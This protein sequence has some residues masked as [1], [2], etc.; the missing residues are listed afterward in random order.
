[1]VKGFLKK[2]KIYLFYV[3]IYVETKNYKEE[4]KRR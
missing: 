3:A 4:T 1:M 2:Y